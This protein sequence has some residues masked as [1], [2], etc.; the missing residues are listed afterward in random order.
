MADSRAALEM[1]APEAD[2]RAALEI[3]ANELKIAIFHL[4]RTNAEL[5][6]MIRS[7]MES[8]GG[9]AGSADGAESASV[10]EAGDPELLRVIEENRYCVEAKRERLRCI[11]EQLLR[12]GWLDDASIF[13]VD[14]TPCA[15]A[16]AE[17]EAV[18]VAAGGLHL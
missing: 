7:G 16:E 18:T 9:D 2:S 13:D 11:V 4:R 3:D 10:V 12:A 6:E 5:M 14:S 15:E 1:A 17:A 8:G